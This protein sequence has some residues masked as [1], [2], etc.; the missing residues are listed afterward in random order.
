MAKVVCIFNVSLG[1]PIK[2]LDLVRWTNQRRDQVY[3]SPNKGE[4]D[5]SRNVS[6]GCKIKS[7]HLVFGQIR[8]ETTCTWLQLMV[9]AIRSSNVCLG[10]TI[11]SLDLVTWSNQRRDHACLTVSAWKAN[12][13]IHGRKCCRGGDYVHPLSF[14]GRKKFKCFWPV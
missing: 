7:L 5:N 3:L 13:P 14:V 2:S 4:K 8:E 10:R 6:F 9:K 11:K 1:R 12:N